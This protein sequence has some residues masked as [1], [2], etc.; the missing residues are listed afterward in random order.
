MKYYEE[1]KKLY[2]IQNLHNTQGGGGQERRQ[3]VIS[4]KDNVLLLCLGGTL[5]SAHFNAIFSSCSIHI[6]FHNSFIICHN[7]RVL[8]G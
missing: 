3:Q 5:R 6:H 7:V 4:G 1:N 2:I 8:L